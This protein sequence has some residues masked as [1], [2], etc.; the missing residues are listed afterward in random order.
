MKQDFYYLPP[1]PKNKIKD[2]YKYKETDN[3]IRDIIELS[4]F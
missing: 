3:E 2:Y 1:E 4:N